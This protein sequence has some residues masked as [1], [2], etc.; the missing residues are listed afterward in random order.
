[1]TRKHSIQ[2]T[3]RA[4]WSTL[5]THGV[6]GFVPVKSGTQREIRQFGDQSWAKSLLEELLLVL[7]QVRQHSGVEALLC[8]LTPVP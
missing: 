3:T 1:M 2:R 4:R 8:I 6:V 5:F 7:D